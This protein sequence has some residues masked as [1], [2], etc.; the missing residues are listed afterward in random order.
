MASN[1][2]AFLCLE[3]KTINRKQYPSFSRC[4]DVVGRSK[5]TN[6]VARFP[7]A[8]SPEI[9]ELN[10]S[11][12]ADLA[13]R[14]HRSLA[15]LLGI[16]RNDVMKWG[17]DMRLARATNDTN[18]SPFDRPPNGFIYRIASAAPSRRRKRSNGTCSGRILWL[19]FALFSFHSNVHHMIC[20]IY[21]YG[22]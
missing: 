2:S 9:T 14:H 16:R 5:R 17:D 8:F 6:G 22:K 7:R 13:V 1:P 15:S 10:W 19:K 21:A 20:M 3:R 18:E 4:E 11:T 12:S